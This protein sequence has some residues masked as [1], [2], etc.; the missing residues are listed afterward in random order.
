MSWQQKLCRL[1]RNKQ[2]K[3]HAQQM[4]GWRANAM[5]N[6]ILENKTIGKIGQ[7]NGAMG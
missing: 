6:H 4:M 5:L 7:C 2:H 3:Y 1:P